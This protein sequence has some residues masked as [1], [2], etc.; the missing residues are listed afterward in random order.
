MAVL[1]VLILI[2]MIIITTISIILVR[3]KAIASKNNASGILTEEYEMLSVNQSYVPSIP[4]IVLTAASNESH[5]MFT[6]PATN[7]GPDHSSNCM[8]DRSR[9]IAL[10]DMDTSTSE[11]SSSSKPFIPLTMNN[12]YATSIVLSEN[13]AYE[14]QAYDS[15]EQP[16]YEAVNFSAEIDPETGSSQDRQADEI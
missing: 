16:P 7:P 8:E 6:S 3:K 5:D 14:K 12:A 10:N 4:R 13:Q 2:A 11:E 1:G 9:S 15:M